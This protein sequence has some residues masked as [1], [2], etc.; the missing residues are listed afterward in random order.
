MFMIAGSADQHLHFS[1]KTLIPPNTPDACPVQ[2]AALEGFPDSLPP[3][4]TGINVGDRELDLSLRVRQRVFSAIAR[5]ADLVQVGSQVDCA[6][7]ATI[8]AGG[9]VGEI[10]ADEVKQ[11]DKLRRHLTLLGCA[12]RNKPKAVRSHM[13]E[14]G[15]TEYFDIDGSEKDIPAKNLHFAVRVPSKGSSFILSKLGGGDV[16]ITDEQTPFDLYGSRYVGEVL[17]LGIYYEERVVLDY[18]SHRHRNLTQT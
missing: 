13:A 2:V 12:P 4:P 1:W 16:V 3:H 5:A 17:S 15:I 11:H 10:S 14:M 9:E 8:L 7:F 6:T 18:V